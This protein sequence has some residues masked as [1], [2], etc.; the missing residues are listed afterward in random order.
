MDRNRE[1][2]VFDIIY[3]YIYTHTHTHTYRL[4]VYMFPY[5]HSTPGVVMSVHV[6]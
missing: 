2:V 6:C 1:S 3:I 4:F 5:I